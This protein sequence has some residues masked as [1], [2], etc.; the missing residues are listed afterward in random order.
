MCSNDGSG[1]LGGPNHYS[2][3]RNMP[4]RWTDPSGLKVW[5]GKVVA[6][7]FIDGM[8]GG[9][10]SLPNN[11]PGWYT[12]Q[13]A[14]QLFAAFT[15]LNF[16]EHPVTDVK[17]DV[18]RLY[19]ELKIQWS[20]DC[21]DKLEWAKIASTDTGAG[22]EPGGF[23]GTIDMKSRIWLNSE[24]SGEVLWFGWGHPD[25]RIEAGFQIIARTSVNIW[26]RARVNFY[27]EDGQGFLSKKLFVGSDFPSHKLWIQGIERGYEVQ[28]EFSS[29]W[30][31]DPMLGPTFVTEDGTGPFQPQFGVE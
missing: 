14:F 28:G 18:F 4:L 25:P 22:R 15:A 24:T 13:I 7:S 8:V 20:C 9:V 17:D 21:N 26:H 19:T 6:K 11:T 30:R 10:G 5:T 23:S 16:Q 12:T 3:L 1:D 29:L 27:C 31:S 2:Y